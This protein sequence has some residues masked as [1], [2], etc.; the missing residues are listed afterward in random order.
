MKLENFLLP[1]QPFVISVKGLKPGRSHLDWHADGQFFASFENS[2]I[3]DA[4][5][6]I[7]VDIDNDEFEIAVECR[8]Q[9][10]VT[11][12]C[13]RCLEDLVL[14]VSTS[15]EEDETLDLNQDIYDFVCL[16]LPMRRVHPDGECNEETLRYLSK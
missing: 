10:T 1:L 8:I 14:P 13:D 9:G 16:S 2:E 6:D 7:A 12:I 15:F 11:V 5:L 4:D 3:K